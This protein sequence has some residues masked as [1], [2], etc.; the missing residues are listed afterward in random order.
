MYSE[1]EPEDLGIALPKILCFSAA[2]LFHACLVQ[3]DPGMLS[4]GTGRTANY[5]VFPALLAHRALSAFAVGCAFCLCRGL[6]GRGFLVLALLFA[7]STPLGNSI[8]ELVPLWVQNSNATDQFVGIGSAAT[9]GAY[10]QVATMDLVPPA[11]RSTS[12]DRR[13]VGM[14]V[15][16]GF[17]LMSLPELWLLKPAE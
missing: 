5:T 1:P 8:G 13:V 6:D 3:G 14:T 11:T 9:A 10:L 2:Y 17:G 15:F 4:F 12:P 16:L 7:L